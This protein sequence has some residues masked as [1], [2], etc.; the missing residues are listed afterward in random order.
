[1]TDKTVK[2]ELLRGCVANGKPQTAG[3][4]LTVSSADAAYLVGI[5]KAR[6]AAKPKPAAK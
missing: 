6:V 5:G 3:A 2:I 4:K 1:M